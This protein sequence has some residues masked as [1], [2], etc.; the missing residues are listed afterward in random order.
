MVVTFPT[1]V[2]SPV[3]LALV[4]TVLAIVAVAA[5]P[6]MLSAVAVPVAYVKTT[7]LG[8]PRFGVTNVGLVANTARPV[9][10]SSFNAHDK[11]AELVRVFC[12]PDA[13]VLA[14]A[15]T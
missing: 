12:L 11:P 3:R 15:S 4:V 9:P 6:P 7:V 5:F 13:A 10:V 8:V 14:A 1:E 2:T